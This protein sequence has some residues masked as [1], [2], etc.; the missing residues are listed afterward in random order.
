MIIS[1]GINVFLRDI[2]EIIVQ[3]PAVCEAAVFGVPSEKWGETRKDRI[4]TTV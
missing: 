2:E 3:H 1:G 4:T